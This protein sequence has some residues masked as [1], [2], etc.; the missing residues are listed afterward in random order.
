VTENCKLIIAFFPKEGRRA[1]R[2]T[3]DRLLRSHPIRV[4][5]V[6]ETAS[7]I[8]VFAESTRCESLDLTHMREDLWK[9]G[10]AEGYSTRLQRECLFKA[11]HSLSL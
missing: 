5:R 1:E 4:E 6:E 10:Q 9:Q 8:L 2:S 11:M 7:G 3:V